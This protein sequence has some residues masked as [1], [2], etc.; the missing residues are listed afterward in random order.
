[1]KGKEIAND[2]KT[3]VQSLLAASA[4]VCGVSEKE[5]TNWED[6][7]QRCASA[8]WLWWLAIKRLTRYSNDN[9]SHIT[10]NKEGIRATPDTISKGVSKMVRMTEN[11]VVWKRR[12]QYVKEIIH[13]LEKESDINCPK[14]TPKIILVIPKGIEVE[15]KEK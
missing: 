1:M 2:D 14:P 9:I 12:W 10:V 3:I 11:E 7:R 13:S 6:R 5:I 4:H 8:R 15:I